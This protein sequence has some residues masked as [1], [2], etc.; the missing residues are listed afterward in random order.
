MKVVSDSTCIISLAKI[1]KLE[2]LKE[3]FGEILIPKAVYGEIYHPGKEGFEE[4]RRAIFIKTVNISDKKLIKFLKEYIDDG[5]TESI[6]LA[7]ENNADLI[8][9][10]DRDA[11][12]I[13]KR[14]NLRVIGTL[15][16]LLLASKNGIIKDIKPVIGKLKKKG[17]Y[18]SK[19]L[20][21]KI[22]EL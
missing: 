3:L 9:L 5:E 18:I 20:E 22:E 7:I 10:D 12:K 6:V 1:G 15:G 17:F 4:I 8:I 2:I 14:F 13:A 19:N 21:D 11:R 16:I